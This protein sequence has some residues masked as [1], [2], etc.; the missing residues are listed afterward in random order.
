M[1]TENL[2]M[3]RCIPSTLENG[4]FCQKH[5]QVGYHEIPRINFFPPSVSTL[6]D[7]CTPRILYIWYGR[8][9]RLPVHAVKN[10]WENENSQDKSERPVKLW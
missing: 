9:E 4:H 5:M 10:S 8:L 3:K 7:K 2:N 1:D 6:S